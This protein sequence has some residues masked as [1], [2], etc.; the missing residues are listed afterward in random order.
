MKKYTLKKSAFP[1]VLKGRRTVLRKHHPKEANA[2]FAAIDKD[3]V[4]LGR[5]LPWALLT[6]TPKHTLAFIAV[7]LEK[8]KIRDSFHYAVFSADGQF[9]G[10]IGLFDIQWDHGCAEIGYWLT[11]DAEGQGLMSDAV[12]TLE[13]VAFQ[14]KFHRLEIRCDPA[15]RKSSAVPERLGYHLDGRLRQNKHG[16]RGWHDTLVF[17]K[18]GPEKF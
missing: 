10:G 14:K 9:I 12:R 8:W 2:V 11:Q 5:F 17:G 15:N 16:T 1:A 3:R 18:L 7:S 4:R 6:K 13:A